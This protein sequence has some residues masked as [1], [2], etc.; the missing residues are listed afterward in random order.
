MFEFL[1]PIFFIIGIVSCIFNII[2]KMNVYNYI[3]DKTNNSH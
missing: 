1:F 2:Y 3:K